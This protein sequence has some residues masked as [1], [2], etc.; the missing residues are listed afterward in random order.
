MINPQAE[1]AQPAGNKNLTNNT[2]LSSHYGAWQRSHVLVSFLWKYLA[3]TSN[4]TQG[5]VIAALATDED[6]LIRRR[7]AENSHCAAEVLAHLADD[8]EAQVRAAV[9]HNKNTP[10]FVLRKLTSDQS[11]IVRFGIAANPEMP[12]AILL[13]LFM[14]PDPNVAER[15]SKTLAA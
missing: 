13:S 9:A 14:D 8:P 7:C 6:P 1:S 15:A 3:A 10:L 2:A 11:P 5:S 12:D 4:E